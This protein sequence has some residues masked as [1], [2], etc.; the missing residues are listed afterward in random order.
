MRID[1]HTHSNVSDGTQTPTELVDAAVVAGLDVLGL[2]D[3]DTAA[4]WSEATAAAD[5]AGLGLLLGMEISTRHRGAG[6]H[7]LAYRPD[8]THPGLVAELDRIVEGRGSRVPAMLE[9]LRDLGIDITMDDVRADVPGRPHV[10]DALVR[11]GV[12]GHRDEAFERFL[13]EGRPAYVDRYAASLETMIGLV[14]DAGGA[15]VIAHPWGR[16][17]RDVLTPDE[18][19]R[20]A[21]LGLDGL[22]VDHRDHEQ[23]DVRDELRGI[24]RSLDLVV[25]GSSDHHG[26]GK[27]NHELGCHTTAPE[28]YQRLLEVAR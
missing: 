5:R 27:T 25:T 19:A 22:E 26:A 8:P 13:S 14:R 12:V 28:E 11:R 17:S 18:L 20:L 1:L 2:T 24:A 21:A 7:L 9:A 15:S 10:A 3:H 23:P 4:G 6:V 16:G